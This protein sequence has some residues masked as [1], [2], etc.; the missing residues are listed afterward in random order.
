MCV[1]VC[2]SV[3]RVPGLVLGNKVYWLCLIVPLKASVGFRVPTPAVRDTVGAPASSLPGSRRLR[4]MRDP[5]GSETRVCVCVCVR[6]CVS[7][8]VRVWC[9]WRVCVCVRACVR[10]CV[11]E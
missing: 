7:A 9:V 10:A 3:K 5:F 1:C 8:C 4:S 2:V 6:A 11:S